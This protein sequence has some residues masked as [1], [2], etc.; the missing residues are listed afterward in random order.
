MVS[1]SVVYVLVA[2]LSSC[3]LVGNGG[4]GGC[5]AADELDAGIGDCGLDFG[6][7]G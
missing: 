7:A 4:V 2:P 6:A 3:I 1:A 5:L